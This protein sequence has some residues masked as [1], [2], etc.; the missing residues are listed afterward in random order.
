M[1]AGDYATLLGVWLA[2]VL[3]PGPD[4]A[5]V[6]RAALR[7]G[8][9][10]ALA[11]TAGIVAGIA[12]WTVIAAAG[13]HALAGDAPRL[14]AALEIAGGT[15]LIALAVL[16]LR[17]ARPSA[18]ADGIPATEQDAADV[19]A[20]EPHPLA[21]TSGPLRRAFAVALLANLTNPKALVFFTTIFAVLVPAAAS[22][23]D[24]V[25]AGALLVAAEAAWFGGV[26][27]IATGRRLEP[28]IARHSAALTGATA[29]ALAALGVA[30]VVAGIRGF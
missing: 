12:V 22:T 1:Q 10:A 13:V 4:L 29:L 8:R 16:A 17:D 24:R 25:L 30:A 6:L 27:L 21:S 28:W 3:A 18:G 5:I 7:G 15:Y 20:S 2:A 9:P 11:A 23:A 19:A 14:L 26:A